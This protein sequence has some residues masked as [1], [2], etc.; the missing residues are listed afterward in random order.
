ML[1]PWPLKGKRFI[2]KNYRWNESGKKLEDVLKKAAKGNSKFEFLI[3]N[4]CYFRE[5]EISI[6]HN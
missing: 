3:F 5:A 1:R 6:I 4:C 2:L